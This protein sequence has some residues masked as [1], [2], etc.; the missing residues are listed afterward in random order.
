MQKIATLFKLVNWCSLCQTA[1]P[2]FPNV[3][4]VSS[5][6]VG[7]V[8]RTSKNEM[9][10]SSGRPLSSTQE[11]DLIFV[12]SLKAFRASSSMCCELLCGAPCT[13]PIM[14]HYCLGMRI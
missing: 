11:N 8:S 13:D 5:C 10:T 12:Q 4:I 1:S 7:K 3:L 14:S 9:K 2:R 6:K